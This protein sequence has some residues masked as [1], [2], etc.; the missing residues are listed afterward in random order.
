MHYEKHRTYDGAPYINVTYSEYPKIP[1]RAVDGA[2]VVVVFGGFY[3][4][5]NPLMVFSTIL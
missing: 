2:N 3:M 4:I 1:D 5:L